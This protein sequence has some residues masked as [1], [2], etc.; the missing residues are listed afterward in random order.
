MSSMSPDRSA[1]QV[2][3]E[4]AEQV[5]GPHAA[6]ASERSAPHLLRCMLARSYL[7]WLAA[8]MVVLGV[9]VR[10]RQYAFRR[11]LWL[12]EAMVALNIGS[13]GFRGL[14]RPLALNQAAPVGWLWLE[15]GLVRLFGNNEYSQR[16]VSLLA[17]IG[18]LVLLW[19]VAR[20][21]L[22][23]W[24]V[25]V[26]LLLAATSPSLIRYSNEAKQYESDA[27]AGLV[28]LATALPLLPGAGREQ[29]RPS[30]RS[31]LLW[32]GLGAVAIWC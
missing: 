24:L 13:R 6:R 12:D 19:H 3:P 8:A 28:L 26:V 10:V 32:G 23:R 4:Q 5:D 22:P 9:V 25:P 1:V 30:W 27:F 31:F 16:L 2:E 14:L 18:V 11:S 21:L 7:D 15:H 29:E 20:Q 17:G